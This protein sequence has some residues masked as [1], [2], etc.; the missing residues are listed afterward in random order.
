MIAEYFHL[1]NAGTRPDADSLLRVY[2]KVWEVLGADAV[3]VQLPSVL[4]CLATAA[5]TPAYAMVL[6]TRGLFT[7]LHSLLAGAGALSEA[8]EQRLLR[9]LKS[10]AAVDLE[11]VVREEGGLAALEWLLQA[12]ARQDVRMQALGLVTQA[13]TGTSG[14]TSRVVLRVLSGSRI[15]RRVTELA[16]T[17][18][19]ER[20]ADIKPVLETI[21]LCCPGGSVV[22]VV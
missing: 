19:D 12:G 21:S 4:S 9:L 17:L 8:E 5:E 10:V 2:P 7:G 16:A 22:G 1:V 18:L 13:A 14:G 20:Y 15:M 11:S 3:R 6:V